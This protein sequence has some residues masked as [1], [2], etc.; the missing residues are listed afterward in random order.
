[1]RIS[2]NGSGLL[3]GASLPSLVDHMTQASEDGFPTYWLAQ[4]GLVDALTLFAAAADKVPGIE[5]GTAVVPTYTRHPSA[6]ASQAL[7]AQATTGGRI[8]LGIGL[9][10]QPVVEERWGMQWQKPIRHMLDYLDV[11]QPLLATG[12]VSHHGEVFTTEAQLAL[13]T[14]DP[15]PIM[16]A[17]LGSQMLRIAGR[18]TAG[19]I[20]WMVGPRTISDHIAPE[21]GEAAAEVGRPVPRIMCSL[22]T[23]VTEDEGPTR[24]FLGTV[25]ARYGELPS[26]RA[27]LDREGAAGPGDVAVVGDEE[28][29]RQQLGAIA[30][31]GA[32]EFAAVEV[33][34]DPDTAARTRALLRELDALGSGA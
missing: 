5:L 19:T 34:R 28:S 13:P 33:A 10:H 11:L 26:Y 1:V 12:K 15:P 32:T 20:L 18:R 30:E 17:A 31:S 25:L 7:T 23:V 22:P 21:I 24:D 27:M 9:N 14:D 2:I 16:L 8:V 4:T 6:L 3:D 29:V